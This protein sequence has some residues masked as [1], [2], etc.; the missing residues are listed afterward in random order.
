M[1]INPF[2][3]GVGATILFEVVLIIIV[4]VIFAVKK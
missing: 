4:I 3:A 2:W 1:Y